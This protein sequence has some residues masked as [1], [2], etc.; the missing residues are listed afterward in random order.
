MVS[1]RTHLAESELQSATVHADLEVEFAGQ[2]AQYKQVPFQR[3]TQG[4][5]VHLSGMI[6]AKMSDFKIDRPS[7]LGIAVKDDMPIQVEMNWYP[8]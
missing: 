8:M 2:T 6:P 1:V 3:T 5:T 4:N 7:L